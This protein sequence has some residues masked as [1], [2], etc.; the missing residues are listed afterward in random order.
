ML[1]LNLGQL[2]GLALGPV[3]DYSGHAITLLALCYLPGCIGAWIQI[4]RGTKYSRFPN[5]LDKW[6][7]MR[8]QL[9]LLMLFSAS[10]HVSTYFYCN[11]WKS[12]FSK[13]VLRLSDQQET[14]LW[15]KKS[16]QVWETVLIDCK[17]KIFLQLC[18]G[19]WFWRGAINI[20]NDGAKRN[21]L[22]YL[23]TVTTPI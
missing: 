18:L 8:K 7:K 14:V 5:W 17:A 9:G 16:M 12:M 10:L 13:F 6:L 15:K 19:F 2:E 1:D 21:R 11:F 3:W 22:P 20:I 4:F 23:K